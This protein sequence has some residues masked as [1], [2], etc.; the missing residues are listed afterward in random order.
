M[1]NRWRI[2]LAIAACLAGSNISAQP[3]DLVPWA[4]PF[5]FSL[6]SSKK[7]STATIATA[8]YIHG[9]FDYAL[10]TVRDEPG[11]LHIGIAFHAGDRLEIAG[12]LH[13]TPQQRLRLIYQPAHGDVRP[14]FFLQLAPDCQVNLARLLFRDV[15]GRPVRLTHLNANLEQTDTEDLNPAVPAGAD[16]GG[17]AV[18]HVD[19]GVN[20]LLPLINERLARNETGQILGHDFADDDKRPFD[21]DPSRPAFFPIRHGT[22]V[23]SVLI[24]EAPGI[25]LIPL[26]HPGNH[27]SIFADVVKHIAGGPARI[28]LMPLGGYKAEDWQAF[29]KEAAQHPNILFILSAG[30]NGRNIDEEPVY[31]ASLRLGNGIV[32][33]S[34]DAFGKIAEGSNWGAESVDIAVPGERI[35]VIDHKGAKGRASGSSYAAPRIA[36][37]ASRMLALNPNMTAPELKQAILDLA[38]PLPRERTPRTR[39]GWIANP[40]LEAQDP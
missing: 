18:A 20:Y 6:C 31:P 39:H 4:V 7:F 9:L 21:L 35:D 32:V 8:M 30:N 29:E 22:T 1:A 26:R 36:A 38:S 3:V 28:V 14:G 12:R 10:E 11:L 40:A 24:A 25:R 5:S 23:A 19:S 33:T 15:E 13:G 17:V 27:F 16:P 37:L 34:S 2:S